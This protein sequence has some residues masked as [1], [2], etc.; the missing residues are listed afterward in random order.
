MPP[1]QDETW[2]NCVPRTLEITHVVKTAEVM[3]SING[4][5][6]DNN[7]DSSIEK[8]LMTAAT[9]DVKENESSKPK[10]ILRRRNTNDNSDNNVNDD[11]KKNKLSTRTVHFPPNSSLITA[12]HTRPSTNILEIPTL[13]YCSQEIRQFKYDYRKLLRAQNEARETMGRHSRQR[14]NDSRKHKKVQPTAQHDNTF[15]R[16]KVSRRLTIGGG[17]VVMSCKLRDNSQAADVPEE[18][19]LTIVGVPLWYPLNG[20]SS[21]IVPSAIYDSDSDESSESDESLESTSSSHTGIFSSVFDVARDAV[22]ILNGP[23]PTYHYQR[24]SS[25]KSPA[26]LAA[27]HYANKQCLVDTLYLF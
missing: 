20:G 11:K 26:S 10:S 27:S 25:V 5:P 16:S 2:D 17:S 6:A 14:A 8:E 13:Y 23:S 21:A 19:D 12:I 9:A 7:V 4:D 3:A 1:F 22:S 18:K 24:D 15:W